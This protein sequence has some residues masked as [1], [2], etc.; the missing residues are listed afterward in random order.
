[1]VEEY[2][3]KIVLLGDGAVGKT[4]LVRRYV[5]QKF[6]DDY[7]STI[8]ANFKKKVIDYEDK[9]TTLKLMIGDLIGQQGFQKTQKANMKGSNGA[10]LV[11]DLTRP[12]TVES[13]DNYWTPLLEDVL[14]EVPPFVFLANK[15]DLVDLKSQ[16]MKD[17][18]SEV[19]SLTEKYESKFFFTSAKTG[20]NVEQ[21][22]QD[23]GLLT[24]DYES[25]SYYSEELYQTKEGLSKVEVLDLFK[26]QLYL[27]LGG[28]EFVNPILQNQLPKLG[29]DVK[30]E[31][32]M[33]QLEE[34]VEK[35]RELEK[36]FLSDKM[37]KK[38]YVKRK[39]ILQKI[40]S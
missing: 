5:E 6:S 13:I 37:A 22:F 35:I 8:G 27:E 12:E 26:A 15:A 39:G 38:Y 4:S 28:E 9:D 18:R 24:L 25:N 34:L 36:D 3:R 32:T 21:A 16:E 20:K 11:C 40:G 14:G 33:D 29:I 1:M 17:Y 2:K 7:I 23:I 19:L 30:E 31:P 10:L